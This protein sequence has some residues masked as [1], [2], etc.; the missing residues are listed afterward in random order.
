MK[1]FAAL[2]RC[3]LPALL[4]AAFA[5]ARAQTGGVRVG[6]PGTPD[7][8]AALE[9]SSTSK[10]LLLPRLTLAQRT[11]MGTGSVAAPVPGLV[12]YQTD[13]T[14]GLYA[15]DGTAWV[16]LGADNLGNHTATQTLNL[17]T[18]RLLGTATT[19]F[20][21]STAQVELNANVGTQSAALITRSNLGSRKY[22]R[23][24]LS[25]YGQLPD[26]SSS[27]LDFGIWATAYQGGGWAGFFSAGTTIGTPRRW[28]GI[29]QNPGF[30]GF[31]S[32]IRI[33][34]GT[35][36]VGKVLT[37]DAV[38]YGTWQTV[39][40]TAATAAGGNFDLGPYYLVG[41]GGSTGLAITNAGSV[42]IGVSPARAR[43][44]LSEGSALFSA[45][46][47]VP[48]TATVP[49]SGVGR[50]LLWYAD[51]AAFRA[52]YVDN[53]QWD[54]ANIGL[55]SVATGY[56]TIASGR[57]ATALGFGA[58]ASVES[59]V[60][61]NGYATGAGAMALGRNA[62]ATN[63]D[64][65]AIGPSAVAGGLAS[66]TL[67][68][69]IANGDLAIA[70]GVQSQAN[71][72]FS[73]AVGKNARTAHQGAMS[74]GDASTPTAL[75]YVTS[76]ANNQLNM[77]FAGGYRLYTTSRTN[78]PVG[79][80]TGPVA[81][82][83]LVPG[84]GAW[85]T[86]SDRRRKE[87]F[88]PLDAEQVLAQVAALPITEWN[89]KSQ[90]A[91]QRH[92]GPMAQDFYAAFHLDG[93]GRDTTINS[94]DIDGVNMLAIQ[95]LYREV[96]QL[97]AD[98]ARLRQQV[99]QVAPAPAPGAPTPAPRP[100]RAGQLAELSAENAALRARATTAEAQAAQATATL[101]T[102]EARLRRLEAATGG[103]ARR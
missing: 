67:G 79:T 41:N 11:A 16:R 12:I 39:A 48:A 42:G 19:S 14:P 5:P 26:G 102:F 71:G 18:Q 93:I 87:N 20:G 83:E 81:G 56:G 36:G 97:K 88:R 51:K 1:P 58:T 66:I 23:T 31:G 25:G 95:G 89:Y 38:G 64:A 75:D 84:A 13:N 50:R 82:V 80:V 27:S 68:P 34:D 91:E 44:H 32:A 8:S 15:Y 73:V 49:L 2:R 10:G 77:R 24:I 22:S 28:V 63:D 4:V 103:Q 6:T 99:A 101:E 9:V 62:Q 33:V 40:A 90:P 21:D 86:L 55:Y 74:F 37:S 3:L 69:S 52:G 45:A 30:N 60:A 96:Q 29:C 54:D 85:T 53:N 47:D 17:N 46:G 78:S 43:L 7:P 57:A 98:N 59:S 94:A 61:L 70:M 72:Q 100:S 76:T 35:Q 65:V 92:I